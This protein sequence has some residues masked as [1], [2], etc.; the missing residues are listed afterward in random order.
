M[1]TTDLRSPCHEC[2][3]H[4]RG[5][6]KLNPVYP[7]ITCRRRLDYVAALGNGPPTAPYEE[8]VFKVSTESLDYMGLLYAD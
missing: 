4:L 7:C 1:E 5:V 3:I 8:Y 2:I 6:S